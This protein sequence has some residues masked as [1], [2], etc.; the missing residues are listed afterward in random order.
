MLKSSD[1]CLN[2]LWQQLLSSSVIAEYAEYHTS[3]IS[4]SSLNMLNTD[5]FCNIIQRTAFSK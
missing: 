5:A 3:D 2:G 4:Q 1:F